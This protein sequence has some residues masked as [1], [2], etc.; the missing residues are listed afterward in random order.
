MNCGKG[1]RGRELRDATKGGSGRMEGG[2]CEHRCSRWGGLKCGRV[3][4]AIASYLCSSKPS[5]KTEGI[6]G[7]RHSKMVS[8]V[9]LGE[10]TAELHSL[11]CFEQARA[12]ER[13]WAQL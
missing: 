8:A 10:R 4:Q 12:V 2:T 13:G 9:V 6:D 1:G 7:R 5:V 3:V 11:M